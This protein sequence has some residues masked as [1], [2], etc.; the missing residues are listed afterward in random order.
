[1]KPA[2]GAQIRFNMMQHLRSKQWQAGVVVFAVTFMSGVLF[3]DDDHS[4][5]LVSSIVAVAVALNF[6]LACDRR[7]GFDRFARNFTA[8]SSILLYK[9]VATLFL[10]VALFAIMLVSAF[11]VWGDLTLALWYTCR[12]IVVIWLAIP[13]AL[14]LE[15]VITTEFPMVF[16]TAA[17]VV[18]V[19]VLLMQER[20]GVLDFLGLGFVPKSYASLGRVTVVNAT[21][22]M[23][24]VAA[25]VLAW[26]IRHRR[27]RLRA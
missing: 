25:S 9:V 13:L 27:P 26:L 11:I 23:L 12:S 21:W 24:F 7:S 16:A 4:T 2:R 6:G 10:L 20:V 19:S 8:P 22:N 1:M 18:V 3:S 17:I 15:I 5:F 14:L